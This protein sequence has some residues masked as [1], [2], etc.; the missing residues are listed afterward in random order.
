MKDLALSVFLLVYGP[1]VGFLF[2]WS[3]VQSFS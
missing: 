2:L 1:I 3:L